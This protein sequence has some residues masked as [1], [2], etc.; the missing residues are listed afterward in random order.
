MQHHIV[1]LDL[2]SPHPECSPFVRL[3]LQRCFVGSGIW[4]LQRPF[5]YHQHIFMSKVPILS[6][7]GSRMLTFNT[8]IAPAPLANC[9]FTTNSDR[10]KAIGVSLFLADRRVA[11]S[12][13]LVMVVVNKWLLELL[14]LVSVV[15]NPL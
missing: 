15:F 12:R 5:E 3:C 14:V 7:G 4:C 13:C 1:A 10:G 11:S 8:P 6:K 9:F 2:Y